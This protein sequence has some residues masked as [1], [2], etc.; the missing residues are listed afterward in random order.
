MDSSPD[1]IKT[2]DNF[3]PATSFHP[4]ELLQSTQASAATTDAQLYGFSS[5]SELLQETFDVEDISRGGKDYTV[6]IS[7]DGSTEVVEQLPN[8]TTANPTDLDPELRDEIVQFALDE[9]ERNDAWFF[10]M[11]AEATPEE[12]AQVA[13][14]RSLADK[15]DPHVL[16]E[17]VAAYAGRPA[18]LE[19]LIQIA[20]AESIVGNEPI[21]FGTVRDPNTDLV[22]VYWVHE[23]QFPG[24]MV[25]AQ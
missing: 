5:A 14:L 22:T 4:L 23:K 24:G 3:L 1:A 21:R 17:V 19:R 15:F 8:G 25:V 12:K 20:N 10:L 13:K 7:A 6:R 16:N 2:S 9:K 18:E 11:R